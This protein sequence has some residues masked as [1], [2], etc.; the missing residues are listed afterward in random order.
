MSK[1]IE[2]NHVSLGGRWVPRMGVPVL[3]RTAPQ[4]R[5]R[6]LDGAEALLL[7]R[8]TYE[9]LAAAYTAMPSNPFVDRMNSIAKY[10]APPLSMSSI[11]TPG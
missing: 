11:G 1:L 4:L 7:G 2:M 6:N 5:W 3:G 8:K 9:G 10:V